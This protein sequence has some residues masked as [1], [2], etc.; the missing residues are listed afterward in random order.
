M[1]NIATYGGVQ[2]SQYPLSIYPRSFRFIFTVIIPLACVTYYPIAIL[3]RHAAVPLF[4]GFIAPLA[5]LII[6]YLSCQLWRLGVS[7]YCST[8]S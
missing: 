6:L 5:G 3:L 1:M 7:R 8:G 2:T 4:L